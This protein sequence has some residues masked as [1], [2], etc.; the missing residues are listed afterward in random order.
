[1]TISATGRVP[2]PVRLVVIAVG[3]CAALV[4]CRSPSTPRQAAPNVVLTIGVPLRTA[5]ANMGAGQLATTL[6]GEG[7]V[8]SNRDGRPLDLL[9]AKWTVSPDGLTIAFTL[10]PHVRFHDGSLLTA[11]IAKASLDRSRTEDGQL[12]HYPFLRDIERVETTRD[13][14][15]IIRLHS[16]S[17]L[18]FENLDV[19][20]TRTLDGREVSP[21]PF[22]PVASGKELSV[23]A[24]P[25]YQRGKPPIDVIRFKTY[26]ALRP[27][28]A[29]LM[30]GEI[31]FLYDVGPESR[32]FVEQETSVRVYPYQRAFGTALVPNLRRPMFQS[33]AVR[34]A[35]SLAIDRRGI[36]DRAFHGRGAPSNG[37]WPRHWV[38]RGRLTDPAYDPARADA[39]LT[40]NGYGRPDVARA[41]AGRMPSRLRFTCLVPPQYGPLE[42][43]A[44]MIQHQL[45]AIDVDM[46]IEPLP[47]E[48]LIDRMTKGDFDAILMDMTGGP[49]IARTY[50]IWHSTAQRGLVDFGYRAADAALDRI[51]RARD[52][53]TA[54]AGAD[55]LRQVFAEDPPAIFIN[56]SEAARAVSR[57]F[58]ADTE[59]GRDVF[60]ALWRMKPAG[61]GAP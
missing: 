15:L 8:R 58:E 56:W 31:D 1:M 16:P 50:Y 42:R 25:H 27:A 6:N 54:Y 40:A 18:L 14:G 59:P 48:Q 32:P 57:R 43:V 44:L 23:R 38:Y 41:T 17:A 55:A 22:F 53:E 21:G 61:G 10:K 46:Q 7:L 13:N 20:I 51:R 49:G 11:A 39:L 35:L 28:W 33:A 34:R 5:S 52:E 2:A 60:G 36:I 4:G 12:A 30:R 47:V 26:D 29:A 24:N 19:P 37:L 45:H 3:V 9:A